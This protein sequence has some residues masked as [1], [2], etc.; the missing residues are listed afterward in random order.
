MFIYSECMDARVGFQTLFPSPRTR[1]CSFFSFEEM[2]VSL[3]RIF[4]HCTR[5]R[6]RLIGVLV[7]K[8]TVAYFYLLINIYRVCVF[9]LKYSHIHEGFYVLSTFFSYMHT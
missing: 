3:A 1:I 2:R 6:V 7:A 9:T 4:I 5:T 8:Q